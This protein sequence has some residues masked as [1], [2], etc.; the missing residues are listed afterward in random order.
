MC[1]LIE[2]EI[3]NSKWSCYNWGYKKITS[4]LKECDEEMYKVDSEINVD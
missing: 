3:L 4:Q 1:D 2:K